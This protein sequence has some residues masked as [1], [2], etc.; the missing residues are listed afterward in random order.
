MCLVTI[1]QAPAPLSIKSEVTL[2]P[3]IGGNSADGEV[4]IVKTCPQ[5]ISV[6]HRYI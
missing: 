4:S 6:R 3:G 1:P 2:D 5:L